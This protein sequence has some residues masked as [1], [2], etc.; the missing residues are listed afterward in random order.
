LGLSPLQGWT[1]DDLAALKI[2][3]LS[4]L[5]AGNL[6]CHFVEDRLPVAGSQDETRFPEDFEVVGKKALL[7]SELFLEVPDVVGPLKQ[8]LEYPQT[9]RIAQG[10]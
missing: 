10:P 4:V 5:S 8:R 3:A 7:D 9:G 6:W 1:E 2:D